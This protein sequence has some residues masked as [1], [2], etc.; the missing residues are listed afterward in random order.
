MIGSAICWGRD[1]AAI[2]LE[3]RSLFETYLRALAGSGNETEPASV[4]RAYLTQY[5]FY[6][7]FCAAMPMLLVDEIFPIPLVEQHFGAPAKEIPGLV[8]GVIARIP[9]YIEELS[10]LVA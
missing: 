1:G 10:S 3:E 7:W 5:G 6:V 4:R 9:A 2:A 8:S